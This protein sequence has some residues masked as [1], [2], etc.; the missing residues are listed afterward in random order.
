MS[1][2]VQAVEAEEVAVDSDY[3]DALV[4]GPVSELAQRR[5]VPAVG[6][7]S[8]MRSYALGARATSTARANLRPGFRWLI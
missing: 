3:V 7:I 8:V 4:A 2:R 6:D 5:T 1:L